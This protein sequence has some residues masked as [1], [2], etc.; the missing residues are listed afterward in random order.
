MMDEEIEDTRE[1]RDKVDVI[2]SNLEKLMQIMEKTHT[3]TE[4]QS[5]KNTKEVAVPNATLKNQSKMT[6]FTFQ[7]NGPISS[8]TNKNQK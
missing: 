5:Q 2:G 3:A 4:M 1:L 6:N 8:Q 7:S